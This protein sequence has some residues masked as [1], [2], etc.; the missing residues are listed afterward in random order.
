MGALLTGAAIVLVGL[1]GLVTFAI[2]TVKDEE[3]EELEKELFVE[4]RVRALRPLL[5]TTVSVY[6]G[7]RRV[8]E[9]ILTQLEDDAAYIDTRRDP[10]GDPA[11][12]DLAVVD[13]DNEELDFYNHEEQLVE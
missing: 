9:G 4:K 2:K 1:G 5:G 12:K 13:L 10:Y 8:A 3:D 7:S 6:E 11:R